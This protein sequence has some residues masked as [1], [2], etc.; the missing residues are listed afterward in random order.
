MITRA[1][2]QPLRRQYL[3]DD[4]A[5]DHLAQL[6]LVDVR[7]M[8]GGQHHGIDRAG[9]AGI[10]VTEGQLALGIGTQPGQQA[11]L[12]QLGLALHQ[13]MAVVDRRRH[14]RVG[15]VGGIAEHQALITGALILGLFAIDALGDFD[16]LLADQVEHPAGLA[17]ETDVGGGIA[18]IHDHLAHQLLEIHPGGGGDLAGHDGDTGLDQGL[19]GHTGI[20]VP[21]DQGIEHGIGNLIGNLVRVS[22]GHGLG[23]KQGVFA[24][25]VLDPL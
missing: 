14:V 11:T 13:P 23:G 9:L 24:H 17:V 21:R 4:L 3:L 7:I 12:T 2:G 22:F 8:L 1:V 16:A 20:L 15:F 19:A 25:G 18:D 10:V 5:L 6:L